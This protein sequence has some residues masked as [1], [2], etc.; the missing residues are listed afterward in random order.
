[1]QIQPMSSGRYVISVHII[2]LWKLPAAR[3]VICIHME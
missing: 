2:S 1:M 3:S